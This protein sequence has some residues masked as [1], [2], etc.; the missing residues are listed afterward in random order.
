VSRESAFFYFAGVWAVLGIGNF[1]FLTLNRDAR[2]KRRVFPWILAGAGV[3]LVAFAAWVLPLLHVL[4]LIPVLVLASWLV[5][6]QMRFCDT[7]GRTLTEPSL[8]ERM[9]SCSKCGARL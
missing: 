9:Q 4:I 7:C 1:L 2:L 5:L 8:V 6:R 3:L